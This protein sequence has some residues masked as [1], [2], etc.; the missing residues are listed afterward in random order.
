MAADNPAARDDAYPTPPSP[1]PSPESIRTLADILTT[2]PDTH[3]RIRAIT[4]LSTLAA[5]GHEISTVRDTLRLA[6]ADDD[7]D[8]AER[9]KDA[10]DDLIQTLD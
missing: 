4:E 10:Y 3:H 2:D 6:S 8:V 5:Q 1:N 7:A 9:A